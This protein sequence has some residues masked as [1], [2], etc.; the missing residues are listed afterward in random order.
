MT[1]NVVNLLAWAE[2]LES[3]A[4]DQCSE[5]LREAVIIN[6]KLQIHGYCC[7]G[8][9][10]ELAVRA[11]VQPRSAGPCVENCHHEIDHIENPTLWDHRR[12]AGEDEFLPAEVQHW[13]GIDE[14]NPVLDGVMA[15]TWNDKGADFG[16]IAALIREQYALP[17]RTRQDS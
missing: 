3:G 2:A 17:S 12:V 15:S 5:Q 8:V 14:A 10:T 6:G 4:F 16:V 7:L 13:L 9:V 11:G 1:P